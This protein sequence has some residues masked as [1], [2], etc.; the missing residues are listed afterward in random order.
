VSSNVGYTTG[1]MNLTVTGYGFNSDN[2]VAHVDGQ[3]CEITNNHDFSFSCLVPSS[4]V[5]DDTIFYQGS[6]G[7]RREVYNHTTWMNWDNLESYNYY[8]ELALALETP[9]R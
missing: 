8:T 9:Y 7:L 4:S 1:G 6:N 3:P 5:S 2:I